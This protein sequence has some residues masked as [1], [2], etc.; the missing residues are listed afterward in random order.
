MKELIGPSEE[1]GF[2]L[3]GG[4][5]GD[6][7]HCYCWWDCEPCHYCGFDGGGAD[8]DCERHT[9]LRGETWIP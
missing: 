6:D 5:M 1:E 3:S 8:C 2:C 7:Q 4:D 9:L